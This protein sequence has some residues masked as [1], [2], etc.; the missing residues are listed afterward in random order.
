MGDLH[1]L[2]FASFLAHSEMGQTRKYS[3]R[4]VSSAL[5]PNP[6]IDVCHFAWV[7]R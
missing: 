6:D 7:A 5:L 2:F 3:L 1:L 4:A